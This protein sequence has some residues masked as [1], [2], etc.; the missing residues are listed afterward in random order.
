MW[1]R[2]TTAIHI[3]IYFQRCTY[4]YSIAQLNV[5]LIIYIYNDSSKSLF[6]YLI[7]H[8][9]IQTNLDTNFNSFYFFIIHNFLFPFL[10]KIII[11]ITVIGLKILL[12]G[13]NKSLIFFK[14][15]IQ[16]SWFLSMREM[17]LSPL[18]YYFLNS[19]IIKIIDTV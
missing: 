5:I 3:N 19:L 13:S 4:Y 7:Y 9:E 18:V 12:I 8:Y 16:S 14:I 15:S 1:I 10:I 17:G 6:M 2:T 11:S